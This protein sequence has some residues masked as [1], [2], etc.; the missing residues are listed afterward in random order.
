MKLH[1]S[2]GRCDI[3]LAILFMMCLVNQGAFAAKNPLNLIPADSFDA[4][5]GAIKTEVCTEGGRNLSSI[6]DGNYVVYKGYDFDS[7]VAAFKGR[8]AGPHP[9]D[10]EIR[11]D[12]PTGTLLGVCHFAG[13]QG[14]QNWADVSI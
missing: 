1:N 2:M 11:L 10:V 3:P 7:G 4:K 9:S 14:W 5:V 13:T 8:L 6:H 12:G